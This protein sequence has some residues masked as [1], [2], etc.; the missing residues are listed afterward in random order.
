MTA[1]LSL[2]IEPTSEGEVLTTKKDFQIAQI[3]ENWLIQ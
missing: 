1:I 3:G 2:T